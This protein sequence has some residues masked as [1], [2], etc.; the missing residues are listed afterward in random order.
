[1]L[2]E[3]EKLRIGGLLLIAIL[4]SVFLPDVLSFVASGQEWWGSVAG[5]FSGQKTLESTTC[6]FALFANEASMI[7]HRVGQEGVAELREIVPA[8]V[9]VCGVLAVVPCVFA[10]KYLGHDISFFS[11]YTQQR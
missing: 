6:V 7:A 4:G 9:G 3:T 10:L 1:M 2:T 5:E 11:F 8:F